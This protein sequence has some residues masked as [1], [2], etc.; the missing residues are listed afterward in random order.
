MGLEGPLTPSTPIPTDRRLRRGRCRNAR[1]E[2]RLADEAGPR[3]S[4]SL[5]YDPDWDEDGRLEDWRALVNQ[6]RSCR[7]PWRR[8]SRR[9][10]GRDR[11]A[12]AHAL[13]RPPARS[14]RVACAR[15][16]ALAS[17]VP[18][19]RTEKHSR[20]RRRPRDAAARLAVQLEAM[21]AAAEAGRKDHDRWLMT[22]PARPQARRPSRHFKTA[23]APRLR[24]DPA[25][26]LGRHD[27]GG[28]RD[29]APCRPKPR[30][31]ARLSRGDRAG[32]LSG[33]GHPVE[34]KVRCGRS[35][36]RPSRPDEKGTNKNAARLKSSAA[37]VSSARG[38]D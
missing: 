18:A 16:D 24:A 37:A 7:P 9:C 27:R 4:G 34:A 32:T 31:R 15:K 19:C 13:A 10:V 17:A 35:A 1:A 2:R 25:D 21:T 38:C 8:R 11:T 3:R 30:R 22:E 20:E 36:E 23:G 33:V 26:R 14:R 5:V 12:R 6:T 28:A 29:H